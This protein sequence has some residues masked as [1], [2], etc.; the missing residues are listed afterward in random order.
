ME[1]I[2]GSI[3]LENQVVDMS[4]WDFSTGEAMRES[5]EIIKRRKARA[6]IHSAAIGSSKFRSQSGKE[7]PHRMIKGS[8]SQLRKAI[9]CAEEQHRRGLYFVL[10]TI[11]ENEEDKSKAVHGLV[12]QKGIM[13]SK[14]F[15]IMRR[16]GAFGW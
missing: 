9:K 15:S 14:D 16:E 13:V 10:E 11:T 4:D 6:I 7:G 8:M 1:A 3:S 2:V 5:M 12:N